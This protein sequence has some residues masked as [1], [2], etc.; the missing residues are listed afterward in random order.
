MQTIEKCVYTFLVFDRKHLL[1]ILE[2]EY[3]FQCVF[4]ARVGFHEQ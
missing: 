1:F 4:H 3:L 2:S